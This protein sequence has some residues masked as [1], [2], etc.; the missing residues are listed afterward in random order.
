MN[1][2][3]TPKLGQCDLLCGSKSPTKRVGVNRHV[4][5]SS[6]SQSMGCLF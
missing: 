3:R 5:A 2:D 1:R 4:K 6:A